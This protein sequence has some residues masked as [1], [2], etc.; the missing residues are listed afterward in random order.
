[1]V[2]FDFIPVQRELFI[3]E[4]KIMAVLHHEY[5]MKFYG[6][7]VLGPYACSVGLVCLMFVA[8]L[9]Q[10][11]LVLATYYISMHGRWVFWISRPILL[12]GGCFHQ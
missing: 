4:A 7:I 5:I 8:F 2:R 10:T 1:M 12:P 9:I 6:A 11:G 3:R